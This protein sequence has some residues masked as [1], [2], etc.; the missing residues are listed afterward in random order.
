MHLER[1]LEVDCGLGESALLPYPHR[2]LTYGEGHSCGWARAGSLK[3]GPISPGWDVGNTWEGYNNQILS[4]G[5]G[6]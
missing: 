6:C 1:G 5:P 4:G 3:C 2:F